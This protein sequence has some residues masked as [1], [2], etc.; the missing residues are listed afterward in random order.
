M[1]RFDQT[2]AARESANYYAELKDLMSE[3]S[4]RA[5]FDPWDIQTSNA[6]YLL[7]RYGGRWRHLNASKVSTELDQV[8][9]LARTHHTWPTLGEPDTLGFPLEQGTYREVRDRWDLL[10]PAGLF[11]TSDGVTHVAV[12]AAY[13]RRQFECLN[14]A[15]VAGTVMVQRYDRVH[16]WC[17]GCADQLTRTIGPDIDWDVREDAALTA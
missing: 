17:D 7:A 4:H 12:N 5:T 14:E 10:A 13:D 15:E 16:N 11:R 3:L 6:V 2:D 9:M 8:L 1:T